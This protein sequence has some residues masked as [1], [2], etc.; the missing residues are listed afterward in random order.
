MEGDQH[1]QRAINPPS[2]PKQ[3]LNMPI[4]AYSHVA[5]PEKKEPGTGWQNH[6]KG[7]NAI[8]V[9]LKWLAAT[10]HERH[11]RMVIGLGCNLQYYTHPVLLIETLPM[12]IR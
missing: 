2:K 4:T 6:L 7:V 9:Q 12:H 3:P 5:L 1:L 11:S 10:E 8:N